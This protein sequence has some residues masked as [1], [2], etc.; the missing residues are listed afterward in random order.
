MEAFLR[1]IERRAYRMALLKVQNH[2][3]AIDILQDAMIKLVNNYQDKPAQQWKPLFYKILQ[4]RIVDWQRQ[5]KMKNILFFWK[6]EQDEQPD[7]EWSNT[8]SD[9]IDKP[10]EL[11]QKQQQ[12]SAVVEALKALPEKQQQCFLLRSWEGLSVRETAVA[13]GCSEGSV[14]THYSRATMK[15]KTLLEEEH[16]ITL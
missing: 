9:V 16:G 6:K 7:E 11:L 10:E 13:M 1:D 4:N 14:K 8:H 5:Q 15:L 2:A 12:Q 3:D